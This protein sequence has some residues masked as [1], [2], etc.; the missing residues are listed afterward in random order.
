MSEENVH[1]FDAAARE[2]VYHAIHTR[3][4]SREF[5]TGPLPEGALERIL[6]TAHAAP[7]VGYMQPWRLIRITAPE[8]RQRLIE[9]V[10]AERRA[11]AAALPSRAAELLELKIHGLASCAEVIV[12]A[13]MDQCE[14][15]I[16]GKRLLPEMA[17]ASA[18]C[19][20]QNM[21][22]A[23]RAEGI[24]LG[25]VSFFEPHAVAQL[26]AMPEGAKPVA[27]LC[28]GRVAEFP[29]RPVLE[30]LGWGRRLPLAEVIFE[31]QWPADARPT[32][33]AY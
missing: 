7:S 1:A 30:T 32:P 5:L 31:N 29:A 21:W 14:K 6:E 18:A 17:L 8:L 12:V 2:A 19:A 9:L 22:L 4:D 16:F 26:C 20:I 15:H 24:G 13:L 10:E 27:I 23:A 28:L 25:W 11:T 33:T 3:R